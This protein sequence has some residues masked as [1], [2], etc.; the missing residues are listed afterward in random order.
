M[1]DFKN[2]ET[3]AWV[4]RL[5]GFGLAA[6]RLHTTQS[7]ISQRI[8]IL[9]Q[10]LGTKLLDRNAKRVVATAKGRELLL[11]VEQM[12]RLRSEAIKVAGSAETFRG[13]IRIGMAETLVHTKMVDFVK[14]MRTVYPVITFDIEVDLS[15]NLR[16]DLLK[17]NLDMVFLSGAML[18]S[19][20]RNL[21]Y[22]H[23]PMAWFAS[24]EFS[25]PQ[26]SIPLTEI[27][28]LPIFTYSKRSRP[29]L[30]VRDKFVRASVADFKI[31][32]NTSLA[33]IVKLCLDAI[34]VAVIPPAIVK[35][36]LANKE[37][38]LL[39]I[40]G[41]ELEELHFTISYMLTSDTHLLEAVAALALDK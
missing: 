22:A 36:E 28:R 3:F 35:N 2:M 1:I 31:Y 34:G 9:E 32:G 16:D 27:A 5:G 10:A 21:D 19:N 14:K 30:D 40:D 6:Q 17:G 37:I 41:G 11:Y 29:H 15:K 18:E 20:V 26:G 4:A 38:E 25:L 24:P 23:Y 7:A 39:H 12:L 33:A 13:H 8:A